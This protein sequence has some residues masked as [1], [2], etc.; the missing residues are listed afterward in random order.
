MSLL[1]NGSRTL[2]IAGTT[3][4]CVEIYTGES[5]TIPLEFKTSNNIP[6]NCTGWTLG[7]SAKYYRATVTYPNAATA[8]V[9]NLTKI[10]PQP[11][12][13]SGTYSAALSAS[14]TNIG[15]GQGYLYIPPSLADG[16]GS[17]NATPLPDLTDTDS[18]IVVVTLTITRID[19][20]SNLT[21]INREPIG[22]IVRYQ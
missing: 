4:Q 19:T 13:G 7:T 6:I 8:T 15:S 18:V 9:A 11:S 1:L 16:S 21:D 22:F 20:T 5:Y 12:T 3:L 10:D 14:F 2:T 17:P